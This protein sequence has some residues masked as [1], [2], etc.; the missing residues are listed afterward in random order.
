MNKT[1]PIAAVAT[2]AVTI[3]FAQLRP[4]H[5]S[6]GFGISL[7]RA[8]TSIQPFEDEAG[9]SVYF[10]SPTP[11]DLN[12][13]KTVFASGI[14]ELETQEYLLGWVNPRQSASDGLLVPQVKVYVSTDGWI[15]AYFLRVDPVS[16]IVDWES[17][18]SDAP[19]GRIFTTFLEEALLRIGTSIGVG[20][21]AKDVGW[22]HYG[23]P[24]ANTLLIIVGA[25][26]DGSFEKK[27]TFTI[28]D[29]VPVSEIAW[30]LYGG[31]HCG[32]LFVRDTHIEGCSISERR[33]PVIMG[34]F[35][36][37]PIT[38]DVPAEV[39]VSTYFVGYN[40]IAYDGARGAIAI[41]Y[42]N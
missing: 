17:Y 11:I 7:V 37:V 16:K 31:G 20:I 30:W 40:K 38:R 6:P 24:S 27:F 18:N 4:P 21:P 41:L 14:F 10:K 15:I 3:L 28:P 22:Y 19:V 23:H 33:P 8:Q 35:L 34:G 36:D 25:D 5:P 26:D 32:D 2:L 42:K 29:G 9:L 13:A 1:L 39:R 12:L